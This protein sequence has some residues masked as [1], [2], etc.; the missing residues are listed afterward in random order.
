MT[1]FSRPVIAALVTSA[2]LFTAMQS[3]MGAQAQSLSGAYLAAKHA[4]GQRDYGQAARYYARAAYLEPKNMGVQQGLV[5]TRVLEGD[6]DKAVEVAQILEAA[7]VRSQVAHMIVSADL[8]RQGAFEALL[9]RA[10]DH[11]GGPG[12]LVDGLLHAWAYIGA[13]EIAK[14]AD[15]FDTLAQQQGLAPFALYHKALAYAQIGE[16]ETAAQIFAG[17]GTEAVL[18]TRR[19]ALAHA[20]ILGVLGRYDAAIEVL[21]TAFGQRADPA[22]SDLRTRLQAGDHMTFTLINSPQDG[23]AE[24]FYSIAE[25]LSGEAQADYTLLYARISQALKPGHT[26]ALLLTAELLDMIGQHELAIEAFAQVPRQHVDY[27]AA[28]LGRVGALRALER[29]DAAI[30]V[31]RDLTKSHGDLAIV[32]S[33]LG[34]VYRNMQNFEAATEAYH[35]ALDRT[36]SQARGRWFLLY[37]RAITYERRDMWDQAEADFRAALELHPNQPQVLNYLGYSLVEKQ[38]KLDEALD[39]IKRAVIAEPES[40]YIVDSL[41]WVL[42]RMGRYEEAVEHMERA[43][44]LMPVD[45]VVT[46]HLGDVYWAVGRVREARFQWN[47]ALSFIDE[48]NNITEADPYRIRRKLKVGLDAVLIE[49]GADPLRYASDEEG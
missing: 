24:V 17:E 14:G 48:E 7:E 12:P 15:A 21:E 39:M 1:L 49:E 26:D 46:D 8:A 3:P 5:L 16:F 40:G 22:I 37:A 23:M 13:G 36:P 20:E 34:D 28:E 47:R 11:E 42:Y 25:A 18:A 35:D 33:T 10:I 2:C 32:H 41:G 19:G 44:E 29:F 6:F 38:I 30:E 31:L 45:P 4:E 43:V 9:A 27:H